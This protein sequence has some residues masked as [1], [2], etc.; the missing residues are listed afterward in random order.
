MNGY[1]FLKVSLARKILLRNGVIKYYLCYRL[2]WI[3]NLFILK[4]I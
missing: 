1:D 2:M 3:V 4:A